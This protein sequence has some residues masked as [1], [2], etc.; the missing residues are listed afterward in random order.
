MPNVALNSSTTALFRVA[1]AIDGLWL[2]NE[3]SISKL[4]AQCGA[5]VEE[6]AGGRPRQVI[7][8]F[9]YVF[10]NYYCCG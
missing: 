10:M 2:S 6:N 5:E 3:I 7:G 1:V 9:V 4:Q 8:S